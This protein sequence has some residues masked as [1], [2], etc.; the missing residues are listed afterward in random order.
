MHQRVRVGTT[1]RVSVGVG[2]CVLVLDGVNV[3]IARGN[4]GVSVMIGVRVR[5]R[6]TSALNNGLP[7]AIISP[8]RRITTV[9]TLAA[10]TNT[11]SLIVAGKSSDPLTAVPHPTSEPS[12]LSATA[13]PWPAPICATS[14][15]LRGTFN[16]PSVFMPNATT[17][18]SSLSANE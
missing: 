3:L 1:E 2:D 9:F 7:Y 5:V 17:V 6:D 15:K 18:P 4:D 8:V 12:F 16:C 10:P 11:A 13:K 14:V